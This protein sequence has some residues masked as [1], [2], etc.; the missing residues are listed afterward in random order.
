MLPARSLILDAQGAQNRE[1]F[2]R[3][4]PRYVTEQ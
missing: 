3:G 2:D 4:I 1:H